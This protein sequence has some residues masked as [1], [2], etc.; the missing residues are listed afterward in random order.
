M[1]IDFN[2]SGPAGI[3]ASTVEGMTDHVSRTSIEIA[4]PAEAVWHAI[5]TPEVLGSLMFGSRVKTTWQVGTPILYQGE[6]Q[7]TPFEDKGVIVE[8]DEPRRLRTTHYSPLS[9]EPD[10]PE[11]Y[12]EIEY[13]LE[14]L[15]DGTRITLS[16]DNNPTEEAAKH[17]DEM[18]GAML[19][20]LKDLV[21]AA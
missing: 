19:K 16:Q 18:W 8:F 9:G 21:E 5:T 20:S 7:G 10:I 17:S 12:H 6:W 15:H 11:N 2:Y 14:P 1:N 3:P 13:L 4:A